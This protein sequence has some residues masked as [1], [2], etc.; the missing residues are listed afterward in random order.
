[1]QEVTSSRHCLFR[2]VSRRSTAGTVNIPHYSIQFVLL[3]SEFEVK[4]SV[5]SLS[6]LVFVSGLIER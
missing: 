1:M 5:F 4:A 3:F 2:K 6:S